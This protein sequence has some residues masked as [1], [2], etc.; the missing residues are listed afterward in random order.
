MSNPGAVM[1]IPFLFC[2]RVVFTGASIRISTD[3]IVPNVRE[4]I[5]EKFFSEYKGHME[6]FGVRDLVVFAASKEQLRRKEPL[7]EDVPHSFGTDGARLCSAKW[8]TRKTVIVT[9]LDDL[10]DRRL[11]RMI[12]DL[13][14]C[15][16]HKVHLVFESSSAIN[17]DD[18]D[19]VLKL[20]GTEI[21][22]PPYFLHG[23]GTD[24]SVKVYGR[25]T[26]MDCLIKSRPITDWRPGD[27]IR[28]L[29]ALFDVIPSASC[30]LNVATVHNPPWM[31]LREHANG[32]IRIAGG[33]QGKIILQF[34]RYFNYTVTVQNLNVSDHGAHNSTEAI[35]A[36]CAAGIS[37][38][39]IGHIHL[40]PSVYSRVD[41]S[42][43]Y[44]R[45]YLVWCI[46]RITTFRKN[47]LFF[48]FSRTV[49]IP[50][51][52]MLLASVA[53]E[54]LIRN[55][56]HPNRGSAYSFAE[57]SSNCYRR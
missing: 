12:K 35:I 47:P 26:A 9:F 51:G 32:G 16:T 54:W 1:V 31:V 22:K 34:A 43:T 2:S 20:F 5:F 17:L 18:V 39:G 42:P 57:C 55:R 6:K 25:V 45:S 15:Y 50:M 8:I 53:V 23:N 21:N 37:N 4:S 56:I 7:L 13:S 33:F 41:T 11:K 44:I 48:E 28:K 38:I 14:I 3:Q 36:S 19:A 29:D 10:K 52:I 27:D 24:D 40:T 46:P 49:W 30:S